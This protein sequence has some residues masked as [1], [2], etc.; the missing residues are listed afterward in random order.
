MTEKIEVGVLGATGTVG[1]QFVRLL[2]HHPWFRAT[3]LAGSER[4]EGKRYEEAAPWRLSTSIPDAARERLAHHDERRAVLEERLRR[5]THERDLAA[6]RLE[7]LGKRRADMEDARASLDER[8][9]FVTEELARLG[10]DLRELE[11]ATAESRESAARHNR[12]AAARRETRSAVAARLEA[13]S[14]D[15]TEGEREEGELRRRWA[16]LVERAESLSAEY[17]RLGGANAERRTRITALEADAMNAAAAAAADDQRV[18]ALD[19]QVA[20]VASALE[21][22]RSAAAAAQAE[23]ERAHGRLGEASTRLDVLRRMHE[24]GVGLHRGVREVLAAGRDGRLEGVHGVVAELIVV[25]EILEVAVEVALGSRLQDIV[26]ASWPHAEA[27]IA[28]LKRTGAGRATFQPLDTVRAGRWNAL[29]AEVREFPGILGV[30][31]ELISTPSEIT[32]VVSALLGRTLVADELATVRA[33]LPR[34]ATGWSVVTV[35]GELARAGGSVTGGSDTR[36]SGTLGRERELR[37]LPGIMSELEKSLAAAHGKSE[38]AGTVVSGLLDTER[39]LEGERASLRAA[40]GERRLQRERLTGW[41]GELCGEQERSERR[42]NQLRAERDSAVSAK[43][44]LDREI[45]QLAQARQHS[46]RAR[47]ETAAEL[48]VLSAATADFERAT[49]EEGRRLAGLEERLRGERRR[50]AGLRS[51]ER[52]LAEELA[53]RAERT[54]VLDRERATLAADHER[55]SGEAAASEEGLAAATAEREPLQTEAMGAEIA[56]GQLGESLET[57]RAALVER[58]RERD[59]ASFSLERAMQDVDILRERIIDD[60]DLENADEVLTWEER[61]EPRPVASREAE[62]SRLRE[63]LRRVGYVGE[64]AVAEFERENAQQ[65]YLREQLADVQGASAAL[66]DLAADLRQTMRARFDETF[67][68]VAA[69][70]AEAFAI[71]FGGGTAQLVLTTGDNGAEPGIDIIAQPPG[72]RLQNLALLSGGERALTAAA[73]LFAILKVNPVPFCLL[74]EVDAA[75]DEANIVR[76]RERLRE[77]ARQTQIIVVTHNRGTIEIADTLYGVTMGTDGISQV[78]SLRL[79]ESLPAD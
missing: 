40:A 46:I 17:E 52:A 61:V 6:A 41:L 27:A 18:E 68:R 13:V 77:L 49:A 28:H 67:A 4:S 25:P 70:F 69:V 10:A 62:I 38:E 9:T 42:W 11:R 7:A 22:A 66:R 37:E 31:A 60:L 20:D 64:D 43:T 14:R 1:Q 72:K 74:D 16:V 34:L 51:Q 36:E 21:T 63:R 24:S 45:E 76:F 54:A 50:E 29:S 2:E 78:L 26:V 23:S 48:T 65:T 55:L 56:F 73:L 58:D 12:D 71:L 5:L 47:D 44:D 32:H 33:V 30:A 8:V 57:A 19:A 79:S 15:L 53:L 35:S 3:W 59:H 39:R 75:L